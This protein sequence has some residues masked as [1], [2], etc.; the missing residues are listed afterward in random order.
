M[1]FNFD[2]AP[3]Q[4]LSYE[5]WPEEEEHADAPL[6]HTH[7]TNWGPP[8]IGLD[9]KVYATVSNHA[10]ITGNNAVYCYDPQTGKARKV[11]DCKEEFPPAS[12]KEVGHGKHHCRLA[13]GSDGKIYGATT[14]AGVPEGFTY[15][16]GHLFRYDPKTDTTEDLGIPVPHTGIHSFWI[17]EERQKIWGMTITGEKEPP[18]RFFGYDLKNRWL[19]VLLPLNFGEDT[20]MDKR[21]LV[22]TQMN[23][24]FLFRYDP[25]RR[26]FKELL[27]IPL[28]DGPPRPDRPGEGRTRRVTGCCC[29]IMAKDGSIYHNTD[30]GTL[31][32][33]HPD[34]GKE[35]EIEVLGPDFA[36]GR[37]DVHQECLALTPDESTLYYAVAQC[38][39]Y[40]PRLGREPQ[41]VRFDLSTRKATHLGHI[42][43]GDY[44]H[45]FGA[46]VGLDGTVYVCVQRPARLAIYRP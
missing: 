10:V 24:G 14:A 20:F 44:W 34:R 22:Y 15:P 36:D 41:L 17:D 42:K 19:E 13:T 37:Y 39:Q 28:P 8:A 35:G 16:G 46:G 38:D 2:E 26:E 31:F 12:P 43:T 45:P 6:K 33:F 29:S 40:D 3:V 21:G 27:S 9:G 5:G 4:L 1:E 23:E 32:V 30:A 25:D 18:R 7:S 11:F